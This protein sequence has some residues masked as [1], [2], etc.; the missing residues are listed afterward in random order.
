[1]SVRSLKILGLGSQ[2]LKLV[3]L[4]E[5]DRTVAER[6]AALDRV[7]AEGENSL[8]N[9][10]ERPDHGLDPVPLT[11]DDALRDELLAPEWVRSVFRHRGVVLPAVRIADWEDAEATAD[12][13]LG[14]RKPTRGAS[15]DGITDGFQKGASNE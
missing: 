15:D 14:E 13:D 5:H 12:A 10:L 1:M 9:L 11:I 4:D 2:R 6:S 8:F 7:L 3:W